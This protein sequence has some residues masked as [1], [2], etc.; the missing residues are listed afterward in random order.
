MLGESS[1][2]YTWSPARLMAHAMFSGLPFSCSY[3]VSATTHTSS[4]ASLWLDAAPLLFG[5][6]RFLASPTSPSASEW[7]ALE[8]DTRERGMPRASRSALKYS[9]S[10]TAPPRAP[11][12][13]AG[14]LWVNACDCIRDVYSLESPSPLAAGEIPKFSG[15]TG[16][17]AY[18]P[19]RYPCAIGSPLRGE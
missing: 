9:T 12:S 19:S 15:R 3:S 5:R 18:L 2:R 17:P 13:K 16:T 14:G 8:I 11:Q 10:V 1:T 4:G 7:T 6:N